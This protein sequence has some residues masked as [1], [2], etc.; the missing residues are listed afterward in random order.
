VARKGKPGVRGVVAQIDARLAELDSELKTADGLM[1]ERRRLLHARRTLTG[2][3]TP[4]GGLTRRVTQ[5]EVA[6]YLSVNPG[7]RAGAIANALGVPLVNISQHLHRGKDT[8][9][10][11]RPDGWFLRGDKA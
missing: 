7:V 4:V 11:R 5:D 9:F 1:A 8:R 2:D 6:E 3:T 10:E